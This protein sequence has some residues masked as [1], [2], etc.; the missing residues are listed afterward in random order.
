V[1]L[2]RAGGRLAGARLRCLAGFS[3]SASVTALGAFSAAAVSVFFFRP[4]PPRV[5]RR[6]RAGF[7]SA[8]SDAAGSAG[9]SGAGAATAGASGGAPASRF[10][11]RN[12]DTMIDSFRAHAALGAH[13]AL[14][15]P[16]RVCHKSHVIGRRELACPVRAR[17]SLRIL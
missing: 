6:R 5:P 17:C 14:V 3:F 16:Q 15:E 10:F 7:G 13:R 8:P 4:R 11:L 12:Q 9:S 1:A 2:F